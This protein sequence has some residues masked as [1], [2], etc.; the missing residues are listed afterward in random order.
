VAAIEA[1]GVA[2]TPDE[3]VKAVH[4]V[5]DAGAG[6]VLFTAVDDLLGHAERI[7]AEVI[8]AL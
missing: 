8:P 5:I 1:A 6:M 7:A 2:G 4:E 3:C